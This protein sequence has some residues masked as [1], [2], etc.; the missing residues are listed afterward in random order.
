M[1]LPVDLAEGKAHTGIGKTDGTR[2]NLPFHV[3]ILKM[4]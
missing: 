2:V 1:N 3:K 4:F